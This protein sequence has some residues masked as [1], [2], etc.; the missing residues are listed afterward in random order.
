VSIRFF[1]YGDEGR[2]VAADAEREWSGWL[3]E[4]F[5]Q[6]GAGAST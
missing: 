6:E 4:R 5:P 3:A 2:A 1:L